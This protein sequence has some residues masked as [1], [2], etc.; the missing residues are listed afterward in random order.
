MRLG[1]FLYASTA[2]I[3]RSLTGRSGCQTIGWRLLGFVVGF[4]LFFD[5]CPQFD[6][7]T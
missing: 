7:S 3:C 5:W 6:S 2:S 4:G 1:A